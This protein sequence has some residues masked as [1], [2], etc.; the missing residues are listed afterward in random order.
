MSRPAIT[1]RALV[2]RIAH[3]GESFHKIDLLSLQSGAFLCLKRVSKKAR[4]AVPDLFDTADI[5]LETSKQGTLRFVNDYELIH[6]RS[7]I[8][9]SYRKLQYASDFCTLIALNGPHMADP[10]SLYQITERTL[11][12]FTKREMPAIVF[13]KAIYLLLK[14][15]GYAVRESWWPQLPIHLREAAK[16]LINQP[17]PDSATAERVKACEQISQHLCHWLHRETDLMLPSGLQ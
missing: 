2:L 7:A 8:G 6:R 9:R 17:T 3:S 4:N 11:N 12:A 1:E 14:D 10:V 16:Q 13:L 5:H 15:E